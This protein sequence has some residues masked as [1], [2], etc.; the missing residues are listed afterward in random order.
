MEFLIADGK[1]D[2]R[3]I[4]RLA[5]KVARDEI[6]AHLRDGY[7][8]PWRRA[9]DNAHRR[10]WQ[11]ARIEAE[12]E[13]TRRYLATLSPLERQAHQIEL[14][15]EIARHGLAQPIDHRRISDLEAQLANVRAQIDAASSIARAA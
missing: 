13:T 3:A 5:V 14:K 1:Y 2:R 11:L 6:A 15:L 12:A 8:Y 9:F 4:A 10:V 7:S